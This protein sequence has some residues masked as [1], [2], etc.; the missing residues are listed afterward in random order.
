MTRPNDPVPSV[1][2]RSKSSSA[3]VFYIVKRGRKRERERDIKK[4]FPHSCFLTLADIAWTVKREER[5]LSLSLSPFSGKSSLFLL[6]FEAERERET[7]FT[8]PNWERV[9]VEVAAGREK[10]RESMEERERGKR[11]HL[12]R[13]SSQL[14]LSFSS[15]PPL[16]PLSFPDKKG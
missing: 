6:F 2:R 8:S 13:R 5:G 16:S 15:S 4:S 9:E 3:A 7:H 14:S 12:R 11:R 10:E 1:F